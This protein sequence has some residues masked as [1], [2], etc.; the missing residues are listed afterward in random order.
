MTTPKTRLERHCG[1]DH[2]ERLHQTSAKYQQNNWLLD[3]LPRLAAI[4]GSSLIEVGC[5]NGLFLEGASRHWREVVGVDWV[6]SP[7]L[8][9][10]LN[11]NPGIRFVQQDIVEFDVDRRFDLLVSADFLE[12]I[13]PGALPR[14]VKRLHACAQGCF[15]KIACYDDGHS[16]LS[17]FGPRAW[18]R[19]F[20]NAVPDGGYRI[21]HRTHR[22]GRRKKLVIVVSNIEAGLVHDH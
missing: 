20:E 19:V 4:G 8:E 13:S 12:H 3:D 18:L 15:H 16:H 1:P 21:L 5:G 9:R 6:R 17:I 10:V 2:Y 22:K 11:D 14:V 7:A